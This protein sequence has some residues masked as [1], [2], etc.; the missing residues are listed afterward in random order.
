MGGLFDKPFCRRFLN[1]S[2]APCICKN[3]RWEITLST[4]SLSTGSSPFSYCRLLQLLCTHLNLP[5]PILVLAF[6]HI[7]VCKNS[8]VIQVGIYLKVWDQFRLLYSRICEQ[9]GCFVPGFENRVLFYTHSFASVPEHAYSRIREQSGCFVPAFG[10][11][12]RW[13]IKN[14]AQ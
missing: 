7:N 11:Q 10:A 4:D 8:D 6:T 9:S 3:A 13:T 14:R 5:E 2:S 12:D 1:H